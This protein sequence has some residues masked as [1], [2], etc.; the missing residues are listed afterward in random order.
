MYAVGLN[1]DAIMF[2]DADNWYHR[3]H[4]D[5]MIGKFIETNASIITCNREFRHFKDATFL[6]ECGTSDG[7]IFS[8]T[9]CTM[10]TRSAFG[11]IPTMALMD[12]RFHPIG[13]RVLWYRIKKI[14]LSRAHSNVA[15]VAYLA[16]YAALYRDLGLVA[17]PGTKTFSEVRR[18]V[19]AWRGTGRPDL[20]IVGRYR[21]E[22]SNADRSW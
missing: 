16:G 10:Y 21:F 13:D 1:F 4:V 19:E 12:K 17:P 6:A 7:N 20:G 3:T 14:G 5:R 22:R 18:A 15:T 11:L 2:L 8:D 9:N